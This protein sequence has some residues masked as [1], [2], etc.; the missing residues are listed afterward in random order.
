[1]TLLLDYGII[2]ILFEGMDT[3]LCD[4]DL[5]FCTFWDTYWDITGYKFYT[6]IYCAIFYILGNVF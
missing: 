1:M 4:T 6:W 3:I 2:T 5:Y